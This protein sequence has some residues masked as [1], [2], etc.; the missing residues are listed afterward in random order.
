MHSVTDEEAKGVNDGL[1]EKERGK[2]R[3]ISIEEPKTPKSLADDDFDFEEERERM[4]HHIGVIKSRGGNMTQIAAVLPEID[5]GPLSDYYYSITADLEEYLELQIDWEEQTK[6]PTPGQDEKAMRDIQMKLGHDRE[7]IVTE[8][9]TLYR[10]QEVLDANEE[11]EEKDGKKP[12]LRL[13][14]PKPPAD[15]VD[16]LT[17]YQENALEAFISVTRASKA[18]AIDL[19]SEL[20]WDADAAVSAHYDKRLPPTNLRTET[21]GNF[22]NIYPGASGESPRNSHLTT[23][24]A[25]PTSS[26][27]SSN[28]RRSS[29]VSSSDA[30]S[31]G[32]SKK[33][34][35]DP[36]QEVKELAA[37]RRRLKDLI[38]RKDE[39][40]DKETSHGSSFSQSEDPED[41]LLDEIT[42]DDILKLQNKIQSLQAER[43]LHKSILAETTRLKNALLQDFDNTKT[44]MQPPSLPAPRPRL[45][46]TKPKRY[47]FQ[48]ALDIIGSCA[49]RKVPLNTAP[50]QNQLSFHRSGTPVPGSKSESQPPS[51]PLQQNPS[52][53]TTTPPQQEPSQPHSPLNSD[54]LLEKPTH[55]KNLG[56]VDIEHNAAVLHD[57]AGNTDL[58]AAILSSESKSVSANESSHSKLA[59]LRDMGFADEV[60]NESVL[61][62]CAG[63]VQRAVEVLVGLGE[64]GGGGSGGKGG[65]SELGEEDERRDSAWANRKGSGEGKSG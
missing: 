3:L 14:P 63:D 23:N 4:R 45:H 11:A 32:T 42:D 39:D 50:E 59:T 27:G 51:I 13:I 8:L 30:S 55:L 31:S 49:T 20:S 41:D 46:P 47:S 19:L 21:D 44:P 22:V 2:M 33:Q 36:E 48:T 43:E 38:L 6:N 7:R 29:S 24:A 61:R 60:R 28:K 40:N 16:T 52:K 53:S 1:N 34:K 17:A 25:S 64:G 54:T 35:L 56:H 15:S 65:S 9:A 12:I 26:A 58:A 18:Y 5:D 37:A 57:C 62:T 10:R